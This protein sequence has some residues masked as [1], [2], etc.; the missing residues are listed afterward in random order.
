L[1]IKICGITNAADACQATLLGAD[2]IGLNFY[3]QSP[4]CVT[5]AMAASILRELPLF[6]DAVGLFVNQPLP[7]IF[8]TL[9]PLSRIRTL[10]WYGDVHEPGDSSPYQ[11]IASFP[12]RAEDDLVGIEH[13]LERCRGA[14]VLPAAVLTDA[15]APGQYG[16]TGRTAPWS[17]LADFRPGVPVI[18]A[19]G[20]TPEN[21]GEAVR[22]VRPY[23][24]DV[25]SGVEQ[26]PGRKDTE[27]MRRFIGNARAAAA[28]Y[29]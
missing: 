12:V 15:H 17:L 29:S 26:N 2:A 27:K 23:A 24:V 21:V 16:G 1:R 19:G 18:L 20:L 28:K 11:M 5:V 9:H 14:G 7:R 13:Y 3:P 22:T 8:E 4:R 25:A 6:V 10:Q